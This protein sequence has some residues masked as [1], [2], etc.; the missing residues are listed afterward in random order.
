MFSGAHF[1]HPTARATPATYWKKRKYLT[2]LHTSSRWRSPLRDNRPEPCGSF[3]TAPN[4]F[5]PPNRLKRR[6][7]RSSMARRPH[8]QLRASACPHARTTR[9][10]RTPLKTGSE[11]WRPSER[12][13]SAASHSQ[14]RPTAKPPTVAPLLS[15]K[16]AQKCQLSTA[17]LTSITPRK[18]PDKGPKFG[19]RD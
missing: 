13:P 5:T 17:N 1:P 9:S 18:S 11:T 4:D 3:P 8:V 14:K 2:I 12:S 7:P 6:F 16:M 10:R 15:L 19:Y